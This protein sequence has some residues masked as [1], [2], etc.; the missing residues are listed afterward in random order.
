MGA[1]NPCQ[2]VYLRTDGFWEIHNSVA[3]QVVFVHSALAS[4]RAYIHKLTYLPPHVMFP[5]P[6]PN[7]YFL[8]IARLY[9]P[10][11]L[12]LTQNYRVSSVPISQG[13]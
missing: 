8:S 6:L 4:I 5:F 2:T 7:N 13:Q 11:I 10:F 3:R 12:G 1:Q 9:R